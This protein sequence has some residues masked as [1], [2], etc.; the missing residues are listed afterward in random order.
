VRH[1]ESPHPTEVEVK[2]EQAEVVEALYEV[3]YSA[4]A[5]MHRLRFAVEQLHGGGDLAA[6][7]RGVL[8]SLDDLG[9]QT[10]PQLARARPVSRQHIQMMVNPMLEDG[11]VELIDNPAHKRSK[12][13]RLTGKGQRVVDRMKAR[14]KKIFGAL[15]IKVPP[16]EMKRA[17]STLDAVRTVFEGEGWDRRVQGRLYPAARRGRPARR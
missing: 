6:G 7:K 14:E 1:A 13:V 12:L 4:R 5:L 15:E 17:S 2:E 3:M 11:Y 16:R 10:A 9:P 8:M